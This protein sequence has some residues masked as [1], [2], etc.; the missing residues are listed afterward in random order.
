MSVE[1][2]NKHTANVHLRAEQAGCF[3]ISLCERNVI[4]A[5]NF[6][7]RCVRDLIHFEATDGAFEERTLEINSGLVRLRVVSGH[8]RG[9]NSNRE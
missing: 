9:G 3:E 6:I 4:Y 2:I 7:P 8:Q 5:S 1:P